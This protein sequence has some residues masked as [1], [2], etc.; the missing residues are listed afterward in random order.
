MQ[1]SWMGE[2]G[3]RLQSKDTVVFIDPPSAISGLKPTR[4][5][6]NVIVVT[7]KEGRD[8]SSVGGKPFVV[9]IPGEFE[10]DNVFVYGLA[11]PSETTKIH[12]RI[13]FEEL[14]IGHLGELDHPIENGELSQLEGVDI[15]F[16]PVGGKTVLSAEQAADL[17]NQIEPRVVIPIQYQAS[18]YKSSYSGIEPFLKAFGAKTS[19]VQDKYKITKKELPVDDT[20]VVLLSLS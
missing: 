20:Q 3:I 16:I 13:E 6:A 18:G 9:D 12:F 8:W 10:K 11:L 14:S 17:I 2:A 19:E 1:V 15:L 5:S 4:Q 7:Q